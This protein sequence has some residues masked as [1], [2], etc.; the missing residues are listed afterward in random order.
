MERIKICGIRRAEDALLACELGAWAIGF[1]FHAP[2]PRHVSPSEARAIVEALRSHPRGARV[3]SVGV[4]VDR[5]VD[6]MQAIVESV[7]LDV[8]QLHGNERPEV[9]EAARVREVWKAFRVGP[10]FRPSD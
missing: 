6:E 3:L 8:V 4:F 10:D 1:I 2:S 7:G 9:A 5:P